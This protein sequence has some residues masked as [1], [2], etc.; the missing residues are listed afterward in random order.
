[1]QENSHLIEPAIRSTGGHIDWFINEY[2]KSSID[3]F[4]ENNKDSSDV[5]VICYVMIVLL[6]RGK[7]D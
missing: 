6:Y 2:S 1:M 3:S 7:K 4:N 5:K